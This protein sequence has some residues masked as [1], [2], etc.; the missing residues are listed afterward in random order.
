[1]RVLWSRGTRFSPTTRIARVAPKTLESLPEGLILKHYSNNYRFSWSVPPEVVS[2][3]SSVEEGSSYD[4]RIAPHDDALR[5]LRETIHLAFLNTCVDEANCKISI[6]TDRAFKTHPEQREA[7]TLLC[8]LVRPDKGDRVG[9]NFMQVVQ[10]RKGYFGGGSI[11]NINM[12]PS[13]GNTGGG[14][15]H[16]G[17]STFSDPNIIPTSTS[18]SVTSS[19]GL[20]SE[21]AKGVLHNEGDSVVKRSE[22]ATN[23]NNGSST[24]TSSSPAGKDMRR[25]WRI[26]TKKSFA[27]TT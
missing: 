24:T 27:R 21:R 13:F 11:N 17:I 8:D 9:T 12:H 14:E 20:F 18:A 1:M 10:N 19:S 7:S 25:L 2:S 5:R 23:T 15:N 6:Y 16:V 3:I 22:I 26:L 4:D